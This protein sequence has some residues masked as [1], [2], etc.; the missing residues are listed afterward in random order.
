MFNSRIP[1][2]CFLSLLS[3]LFLISP[4]Q[5]QEEWQATPRTEIIEMG[6]LHSISFITLSI[7][8]KG[9]PMTPFWYGLPFGLM[10]SIDSCSLGN[11]K[12]WFLDIYLKK[13]P[14]NTV[15]IL[16]QNSIKHPCSTRDLGPRV[17]LSLSLSPPI[18]LFLAD[19]LECGSRLRNPGNISLFFLSLSYRQLQT[20]R[21]WSIKGLPTR[22]AQNR[23][24]IYAALQMEWLRAYW[25][26]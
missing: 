6:C 17:L 11:F 4:C 8:W 19:S 15:H 2:C 18:S 22:G 10:A 13:L 20:T 23:G 24:L 26:W 16:T 1:V 5:E 9:L 7:W 3:P 14:C 21:F 25:S 12:A